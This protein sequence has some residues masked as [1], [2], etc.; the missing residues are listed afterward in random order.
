MLIASGLP[1]TFW[2]DAVNIACYIINRFM[3]MPLLEKTP[4]ELF[5]DKKSNVTHL[6]AFGSKYFV[7]YNGK[8]ALEKFCAKFLGYSPHSKAYKVYSKIN[9]FGEESAHVIFD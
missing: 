7:H 8:E 6:R 5:K 2:S 4:Y 9:F 1:K 3:I